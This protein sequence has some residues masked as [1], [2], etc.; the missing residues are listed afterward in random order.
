MVAPHIPVCSIKGMLCLAHEHW[1]ETAQCNCPNLCEE[2][3]YISMQ[4]ML[5]KDV[6]KEI[7]KKEIKILKSKKEQN[8]KSMLFSFQESITFE[9]TIIVK[10]FLPRMAMK[11]RVVFSSDQLIMSFGGAIGLFLGASFIS[12]YG[13]M[14]V[15]SEY[16][17][18]NIWRCLKMQRKSKTLMNTNKKQEHNFRQNKPF[19]ITVY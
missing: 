9:K 12:I 13:L 5:Q 8:L 17:F 1:P 2:E 15:L 11:R 18:T 6:S 3:S 14:Y 4:T 16:V 10:L 7:L 19:E